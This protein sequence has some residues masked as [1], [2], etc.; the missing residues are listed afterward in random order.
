MARRH[1]ST[2][3]VLRT[4]GGSFRRSPG[5]RLVRQSALLVCEDEKTEPRYFQALCKYLGVNTAAVRIPPNTSGSAPIS[6]VEFA[7]EKYH[8]D[9]G[10]DHVFC[11]FDKDTHESYRRA[12]QKAD[13]YASRD[14]PIPMR[15]I[16]SVPCFE[17]WLLLHYERTTRPMKRCDE[18]VARLRQHVPDYVKGASEISDELLSRTNQAILNARWV[19]AQQ[20]AAGT[21]NPLT[22]VHELVSYLKLLADAQQGD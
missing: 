18:V 7:A 12:I 17:F 15:V 16:P 1:V 22:K 14:Q 21:E 11:V 19:I 5:N 4:G 9:G 10:Y 13:G 8:E 3:A 6:V 2:R 20:A